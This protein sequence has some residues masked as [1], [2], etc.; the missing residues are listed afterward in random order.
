M[1]I[2]FGLTTFF[3]DIIDAE[4]IVNER[5]KRSF[6]TQWYEYGNLGSDSVIPS[7]SHTFVVQGDAEKLFNMPWHATSWCIAYLLTS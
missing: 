2:G 7:Q 5:T 4:F 1:L 3:G 6:V